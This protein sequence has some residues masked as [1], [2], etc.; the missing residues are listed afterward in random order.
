M[1]GRYTP[2]MLKVTEF[3]TFTWTAIIL[4]ESIGTLFTGKELFQMTSGMSRFLIQPSIR[5]PYATKPGTM[6]SSLKSS[7]G[8]SQ[9]SA[10]TIMS[11]A[12]AR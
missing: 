7:N 2:T 6:Q 11:D 9:C 12:S 3:E 4:S 5:A 8:H 1:A 10:I